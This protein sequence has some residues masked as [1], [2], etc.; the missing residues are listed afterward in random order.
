MA[1]LSHSDPKTAAIYT[2][3]LDRAKL[4]ERAF[5]RAE[6]AAEPRSVPRVEKSTGH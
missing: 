6:A 3:G 1:Y 2:K 5:V 4:A